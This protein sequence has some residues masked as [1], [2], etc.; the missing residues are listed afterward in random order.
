MSSNGRCTRRAVCGCAAYGR[1]SIW[2]AR[3]WAWALSRWP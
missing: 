2:S 3:R 1:A